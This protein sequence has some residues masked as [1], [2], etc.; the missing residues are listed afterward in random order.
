MTHGC[1]ERM[2]LSNLSDDTW[3]GVESELVQIIS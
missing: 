1:V 3:L 2:Q